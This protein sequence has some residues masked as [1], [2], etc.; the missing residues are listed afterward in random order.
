MRDRR[1]NTLNTKLTHKDYPKTP[2]RERNL[3]TGELTGMR[4]SIKW[5]AW[6][7]ATL[8]LIAVLACNNGEDEVASEAPDSEDRAALVA[9]YDATDGARWW[10]NV[11]WLSDEPLGSWY[12]VT[13]DSNGRV[14]RLELREN[15]LKGTFPAELGGIASLQVLDLRSNRLSGP[16][17]SELGD[18]TNLWGLAL[19]GNHLSGPIPPELSSL[20]NLRLLNVSYNRLSGSIPHQL[21]SLTNLERLSLTTNQLSGRIPPELGGLANLERLELANNR[22]GGAIPPE[23]GSLHKLEELLLYNNRLSG[24]IPAEIGTL[25]NLEELR[26][27]D[28]QL[29]G[30]LPQSLTRLSELRTLWFGSNSGLCAPT[31]ADFK[32][33]LDGITDQYGDSCPLPPHPEDRAALG[34]LY[35]AT[36][37]PSWSNNTNWLSNE[38]LGHWYGVITDASGRVTRLEMWD[39]RLS[40]SIP[41][42]LGDLANLE[43]LWLVNNRLTGTVPSDL[44][45]LANLVVL[46]LYGNQLSGLL[47]QSL[48][49]LSG[50]KSFTFVD[51]SGLCAPTNADFQAWLDGISDRYGDNC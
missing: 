12:G 28:N 47:P 41:P 51:N 30:T 7:A 49:R 10:N 42:E 2:D 20:T 11:N 6:L 39:N 18:L 48:T 33:W 15:E 23:L 35:L 40:G 22:L 21:G 16:I 27:F 45:K 19:G 36:G 1:N 17:P 46:E 13:T 4:G 8:I 25:A 34:A 29:S 9:L 3:D 31:D 5:I 50:L 38:P 32:A 43:E 37:G 24:P 14:T 44:G 26:L